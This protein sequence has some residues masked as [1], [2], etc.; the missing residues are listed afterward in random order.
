LAQF[1]TAG[2][3]ALPDGD[4]G[5][6]AHDGAR[7]WYTAAGLGRPVI[8]LHGG[9]GNGENWGYQVPA[10]VERGY[11]AITIDTRGH[12]RS[13]RDARPF[14]YETLAADVRAV[15]D[16]L[17]VERAALVGWSDGATTALIVALSAPGRAAGV[18]FFGG[19]MDPSGVKEIGQ[20]NVL[21]QRMFS[22][23][24]HDYARLSPTPDRFS[25]LVAD[26]GLMMKTE[27]NYSAAQLAGVRVP[28]AIVHAENDEFIKREH[29]DQLAHAIAEA[30]LVALPGVSHF[31]PLQRPERF[32]RAMLTF[33]DRLEY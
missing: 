27:P 3:P 22:R 33:L 28:V 9:F 16:A 25:S 19:N 12:G 13:T 30:E 8:F 20:P 29:A 21:L 1:A 31:A 7:I 10:L 26:V 23:H 4:C 15:M 18:F 24:A 5:Y 17:D 6:I 32:N 2:A 11:R 14:R